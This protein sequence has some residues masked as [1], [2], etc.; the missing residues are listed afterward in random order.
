[1]T[2]CMAH[3]VGVRV[4]DIRWTGKLGNWRWVGLAGFYSRVGSDTI[5]FGFLI[6]FS[7][8]S[9]TLLSVALKVSAESE[10][11]RSTSNWKTEIQLSQK[12]HAPAGAVVYEVKL[13]QFRV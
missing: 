10:I 8:K 2:H 12:N 13:S 5:D 9:L 4:T 3:K 1:M 7:A 6:R 11:F